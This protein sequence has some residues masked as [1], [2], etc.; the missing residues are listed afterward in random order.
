MAQGNDSRVTRRGD[1]KGEEGDTTTVLLVFYR[2]SVSKPHDNVDA[3]H[4][5]YKHWH[6][7]ESRGCNCHR[8]TRQAQNAA[9]TSPLQAQRLKVGLAMQG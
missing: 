2:C 5:L 4:R 6:C 8:T 7:M 9:S 1:K 3:S